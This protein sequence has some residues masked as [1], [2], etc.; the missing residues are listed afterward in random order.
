[1]S[2]ESEWEE[3]KL[4]LQELN[5]VFLEQLLVNHPDLSKSEIRLLTLI[6]VGY[7]QK[8]IANILNI[9]PDSVKK[10][11]SRVRKKLRLDE[12]ITLNAYLKN[13]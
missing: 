2:T 4:K 1:L 6:K 9:A 12:D 7:S 8:E 13:S 10:A 3:F 5:P 11:R